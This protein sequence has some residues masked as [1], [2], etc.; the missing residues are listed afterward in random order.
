M[1]NSPVN[2]KTEAQKILTI[3]ESSYIL[4]GKILRKGLLK[5]ILPIFLWLTP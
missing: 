2:Q 5:F 4:E 3:E 1:E